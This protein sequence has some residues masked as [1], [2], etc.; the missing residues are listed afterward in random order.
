MAEL[1]ELREN[2]GRA[3]DVTGIDEGRPHT[4]GDLQ[5]LCVDRGASEIIQAVQCVEG[6]IERFDLVVTCSVMTTLACTV[7]CV[8]LLHVRRIQHDQ[9]R[10]LTRGRRCDDFAPKASLG[11]QGQTPTMIKMR[12]G[13]Q[14][15]VDAGGI[16]AEWL[17]ILF[18]Q[19]V[20][21]L[22]QSAVDQQ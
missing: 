6:R 22:M 15:V 1:L 3:Q 11:Q 17:G 21:T 19:L 7:A 4:G 20:A 16:K 18:I 14:E 10:Q 13:Q 8:F 5:D 2:A 9:S 12:M